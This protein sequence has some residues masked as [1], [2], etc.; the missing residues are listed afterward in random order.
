MVF[1]Q[2]ADC[3]VILMDVKNCHEFLINQIECIFLQWA[4]VKECEYI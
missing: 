4:L 3:E 2:T 1:F